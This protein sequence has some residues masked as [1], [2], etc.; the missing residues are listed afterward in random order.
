[1]AECAIHREERR[2]HARHPA[3]SSS[4]FAAADSG[5]AASGRPAAEPLCVEALTAILGSLK[6]AVV[7]VDTATPPDWARPPRIVVLDGGIA[8]GERALPAGSS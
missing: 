8:G 6:G 3:V 5:L 2:W 7:Y 1:M 4:S